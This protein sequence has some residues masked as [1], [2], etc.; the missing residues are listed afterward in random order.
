VSADEL[1]RL[2][3]G[4]QISQAIHVAA[5]LGIADLLEDGPRTSDE[6]AA[7][8]GSDA[9]TLYRRLRALASI[10]VFRESDGRAFA[11]TELGDGL[12]TGA[13]DS[14]AAWATFSGRPAMRGAWSA[15]TDSV[16]TGEN[17]FRIVYGVDVWQYRADDPEE[18]AIFD[19][20][21]A[22][23]SQHVIRAL[24]DVYDFGRFGTIVDVGGG[25]GAL[26]KALLDAY[27]NLHGIL[28]D[29][30]HVIAGVELG[31]RGTVVAGSF[32]ESVPE[33]GD[34]YL[35]KWIIHDW[36]DEEAAAILRTILERN[37]TVLVVERLVGL[38]NEGA[39]AKFTDL[40]MLVGP[41]GRERT[42]EEFE[43]LFAASG[44]RL[45]GETPTAG[46]MHVIEAVPA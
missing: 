3:N 29:Q 8:T 31:D 25:N 7:A 45:V 42:L 17:A 18:S 1:R 24:L 15:L 6:L 19:R 5:V 36:E 20:A 23:N 13:A 34:A 14:V 27:P 4:G 21:M 32:F 37:A 26:L 39:E 41:G 40:N 11:L 30:P 22:G 35:L 43:A 2:V 46:P 38:P 9:G 12:R 44:Y 16:R 28:F 33:G 10:G